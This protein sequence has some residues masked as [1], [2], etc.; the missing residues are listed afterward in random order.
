ME[1]L[2]QQIAFIK[3]MD[4]SK[5]VGR[6]TYIG[7]G[8]RKEN[9]AE[10]SWHLALMA[11]L[12]NEYANE[13]VDV[14]KVMSMVV[15]HD[16]I[17]IDA[18][19]TYAYDP[20]GNKSKRDRELKAADR[21]FSMLPEDQA[22]YLRSLWDEFEEAATPEAKFAL[23]LDKMQPMILNDMS[24]GISWK[25]HGVCKE[26]ILARNAKT[27]EGS[28]TLWNYMEEILNKNIREGNIG[29]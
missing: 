8:A 14:L 27:P 12:L 20:E 3:E 26:Q 4:K 28:R 19:D 5:F 1:R 11:L 18:G 17:E 9:D 29:D 21:L 24:N 16:I 25:E 10:H 23:S 6:Q 2:E 22:A 7:E 13:K 15:V